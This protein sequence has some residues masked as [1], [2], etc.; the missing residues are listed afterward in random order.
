MTKADFE[1]AIKAL[2]A[3]EALMALWE[4]QGVPAGSPLKNVVGRG[5]EGK[6]PEMKAERREG[7]REKENENEEKDRLGKGQERRKRD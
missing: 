2:V 5:G 3:I 1:R 4:E 7:E 6:L